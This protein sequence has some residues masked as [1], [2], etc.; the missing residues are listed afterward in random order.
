M[1]RSTAK[2]TSSITLIV[3]CCCCPLQWWVNV[4]LNGRLAEV[5]V[6]FVMI[7]SRPGVGD[8]AIFVVRCNVAGC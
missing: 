5:H 8:R 4:M 3:S 7:I 1:R 6:M 2:K